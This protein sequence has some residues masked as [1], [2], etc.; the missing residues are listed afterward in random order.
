MHLALDALQSEWQRHCQRFAC[1]CGRTELLEIAPQCDAIA[2]PSE[3]ARD[4]SIAVNE[5]RMRVEKEQLLLQ[6]RPGA[7]RRVVYSGQMSLHRA[8]HPGALLLD[9]L[10]RQCNFPPRAV[11]E[12]ASGSR[13]LERLYQH[14]FARAFAP[15][16]GRR[17][18]VSQYR[19]KAMVAYADVAVTVSVAA[20]AARL[21]QRGFARMKFEPS[22]GLSSSVGGEPIGRRVISALHGLWS[23]ADWAYDPPSFCGGGQALDTALRATGCGTSTS[24]W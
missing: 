7:L 8:L 24:A 1:V 6:L 2:Y 18:L 14:C 20:S 5:S 15:G 16:K 19:V 3:Q 9:T 13:R 23:L 12:P 4:I 17:C 10:R 22:I 21:H 11:R